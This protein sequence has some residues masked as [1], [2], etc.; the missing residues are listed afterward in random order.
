[1]CK[2]TAEIFVQIISINKNKKDCF[3]TNPL[4][5]MCGRE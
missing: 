5:E 4:Q 1:L 2:L 3:A